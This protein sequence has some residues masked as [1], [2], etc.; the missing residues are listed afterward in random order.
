MQDF[1]HIDTW[2][3]DLDN[4]LYDAESGIFPQMKT[5]MADFFV[6]RLGLDEDAAQARRDHYYKTYGTTL[7]G[8]MEEHGI[9]PDAFLHHIHDLDLSVVKSCD[10]VSASLGRLPGRKVVFTNAARDFAER[11]THHL[12]IRHH[13]DGLFAIEDADYHPKPRDSAYHACLARHGITASAACMFEDTEKNLET[14]RRLGMTTVWLHGDM[15]HDPALRPHVQ[16]AA[17]RLK[18]WFLST[19]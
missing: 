5:R 2:V 3:F 8:L 19:L 9:E 14:A 15:P 16:H 18:D 11:M 13:F 4:T 10:V 7:R 1:R 6:T 17:P 12:G